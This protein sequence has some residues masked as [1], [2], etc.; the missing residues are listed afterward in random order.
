[1]RKKY[2]YK[3]APGKKH[4]F[5]IFL[6][7]IALL[8][9]GFVGVLVYAASDL[10]RL[11]SQQPGSQT[12]PVVT[13]QESSR[14]EV[15]S[16]SVSSMAATSE[17]EWNLLLV[18]RWNPVPE[19]YTVDLAELPGGE[20]VDQRI[21]QPL[22]EMFQ[23][24][25]EANWGELPTVISG[26]RTQEEQEKL[27]REEVESNLAD[28]LSQEEAESE[29]L[30]WV[31]APGAS[32]HQLGLA[33]DVSG[34][35]YDVFFWLQE[36]SWEY[37][38]I[39]RYPGDKTDLTGIAEE[40]WHYRYVGKEAAQEIYEQGICLEEYLELKEEENTL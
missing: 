15:V 34:A 21:F 28:G 31:A 22:E 11:A 25:Q 39:W 17:E 38:F 4:G 27:F 30:R 6:A 3:S 26:Y 7:V 29:A 14:E 2:R 23:A 20:K 37:G 36:H 40:A 16:G 1:M 5:P 35:T 10:E 24:A 32:E 9:A 13:T 12:V 33:V 18:N 19:N 8:F